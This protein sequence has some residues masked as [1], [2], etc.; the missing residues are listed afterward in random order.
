[1]SDQNG[2]PTP[3]P[4]GQR[5]LS[6]LEPENI[7]NETSQID[8]QKP[9]LGVDWRTPAAMPSGVS[10]A[11]LIGNLGSR[12]YDKETGRN[13]Q[14]GLE[15]QMQILS[16]PTATVADSRNSRNATAGR[17]PGST[18]HAGVTLVDA[19]EMTYPT[20]TSSMATPADM[21]QARYAGNDPRRPSYGE[22]KKSSGARLNPQWS[23]ILM[24]L[25]VGWT[26]I[27][28]AESMNYASLE[29]ALFLRWRVLHGAFLKTVLT[30]LFE[31]VPESLERI[32]GE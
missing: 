10:A 15:Q 27:L 2:E 4:D 25:P 20:P 11:R 13:A 3:T 26:S 14:Y 22:A 12:L 18:A 16:W 29:T 31:I 7:M 5:Q 19:M 32:N 28:D 17:T 24:G 1:M 21:E 8:M 23:G 6:F 9:V 30:N